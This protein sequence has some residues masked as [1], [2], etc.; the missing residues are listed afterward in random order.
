MLVKRGIAVSPGVASAPA[1]VLG[2][3]LLQ[4]SRKS[5]RPD[6]VDREIGRFRQA[7]SDTCAEIATHADEA[8]ARLGDKYGA[9]FQAHMELAQD[10]LLLAEVEQLIV[11]Q[12]WSPELA[13]QTVLQ[14]QARTLEA[15]D[16]PYLKERAVDL[17]DL[18][19]GLLRHLS[20]KDTNQSLVLTEPV[21]ILAHNL[22]PSQTARLD[23]KF[24]KAFATEVGG[25][26][27][28]TAILAGALEIPA[29][30]GLGSFLHQV[31]GG[32][33]VIVDGDEGNVIIAPDE[34]ALKASEKSA[35]SQK[36]KDLRLKK[37][38]EKDCYTADNVRIAVYGNIEFP[39][40]AL[41]CRERGAEG[42]G[43]YRT[44]FLYM[45]RE[46][47]P[48]EE[49]HYNAYLEVVQTFPDRPVVIRTLD[50]GADKV[51][52]M[53]ESVFS[54][55][56]NPELGLRSIRVSLHDKERF[57]KQL[58]AILRAAVHGDIRVMFPLISSLSELREAKSVLRDVAEDLL[59][60]QITHRADIPVGMMVEVP[61]AALMASE[62]AKEVSFFSIGTNDLIQY[63]LAADRSDPAVARY[64]NS[65]DPAILRTIKMVAEAAAKAKIGVTICGQ[66][67]SDPRFVPLFLGLG[68]ERLSV[69][70]Q[71]IPEIKDLIR[72]LTTR[73]AWEI[74]VQASEMDLAREID[75]FL[76][77]EVKKMLATGDE[78]E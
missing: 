74:A 25:P 67:C 55:F 11:K 20:G 51:P 32:E 63:T 9:I 17:N 36:S 62:F 48:S 59:E 64:Y 1:L 52:G 47:E 70:P 58:R 6:A 8:S 34:A 44:E 28:H 3:D 72:H 5:I 69:T 37:L 78:E 68:I 39:H 10:P 53:M 29:V 26:T 33:V 18:E 77:G 54:D 57:K 50:L 31:S 14:K 73:K 12:L 30:V 22:T 60:E 35:R 61:S 45:N 56:T 65:A 27:S 7:V 40:E 75:Q 24:V 19:R 2:R 13:V 15:L 71:A 49:D 76:L 21:I 23:P 41:H 4:F 38:S 16:N 46:D 42:I 43:L 66:M